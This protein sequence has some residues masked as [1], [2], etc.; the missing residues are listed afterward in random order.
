MK[1]I[2]EMINYLKGFGGMIY[3]CSGALAF[4][5][6][7]R[8]DLVDA[9]DEVTGISSFLERTDGATMLYI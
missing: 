3:A 5:N 7:A 2:S 9:V 6:I 1:K 4:H 8:T